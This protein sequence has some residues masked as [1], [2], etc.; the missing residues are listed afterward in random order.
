[1]FNEPVQLAWWASLCATAWCQAVEKVKWRT[2]EL[3]GACWAVH[4]D[5]DTQ[6]RVFPAAMA[7]VSM[8]GRWAVLAGYQGG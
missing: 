5:D 8:V 1:M 3:G 7:Q 4:P 6:R 2:E